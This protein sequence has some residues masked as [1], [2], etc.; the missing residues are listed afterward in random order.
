MEV[1]FFLEKNRE[2]TIFLK[3]I[4]S[5]ATTD[6]NSNGPD[7]TATRRFSIF[8]FG[9]ILIDKEIAWTRGHFKCRE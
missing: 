1:F 8:F 4:K 2:L 5:T 7:G 6:D 3:T 9:C